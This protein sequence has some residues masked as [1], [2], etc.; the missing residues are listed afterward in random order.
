MVG[1]VKRR[2]K[3]SAGAVF[4]NWTWVSHQVVL[5][6]VVAVINHSHHRGHF[7]VALNVCWLAWGVWVMLDIGKVKED[8]GT[9]DDRPE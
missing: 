7:C 8:D 9:A 2:I 1:H 6:P 4:C 3:L 5:T